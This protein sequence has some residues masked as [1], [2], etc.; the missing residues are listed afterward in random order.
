MEDYMLTM[1]LLRSQMNDLEDQVVT[2]AVEE[3][4]YITAIGNMEADLDLAKS[5]TRRVKEEIEGMEKAKGQIC[6][7][8]VEKFKKIASLQ[9]DVSTTSQ[10][11]K[12]INQERT[13]LSAKFKEK[14]SYYT[15][16]VEE[17]NAKLQEQQDW[18]HSNKLHMGELG[19]VEGNTGEAKGKF[20]DKSTTRTHTIA[21]NLDLMTKMDA[22]TARLDEISVKKSELVLK[23]SKMQQSIKQLQ[24]RAAEFP[25]VL[26]EMGMEALEEELKA[27]VSDKAAETEYLH[28]LTDKIEQLKGI[29]HVIRCACG[30]EYKVEM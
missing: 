6:S 26:R 9:T 29:S 14:R 3:Q 22:A 27:L 19:L 8:I 20:E 24:C 13:S 10:A 7:Q 5:E 2:I 30:V 17:M 1:K 18:I 16:V 25:S 28:S 23:N 15:K 11:L 21:D 12:L 4:K